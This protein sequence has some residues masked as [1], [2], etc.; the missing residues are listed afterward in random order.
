EKRLLR[1]QKIM[2]YPLIM[3]DPVDTSIRV[4]SRG[5]VGLLMGPYK[6][7]KS[8]GFVHLA[9]AYMMQGLNVI[10]FTLEDT[11]EDVEDRL[12]ASLSALPL[13]RLNEFPNRLR[14]S[15]YR[16]RELLRGRIKIIDM[17]DA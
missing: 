13:T 5:Q 8:M 9:V 12:D 10:Y 17:T 11:K 7:G 2:R 4:I 14:K 15:F 6:A 16:F 1:R 3:I